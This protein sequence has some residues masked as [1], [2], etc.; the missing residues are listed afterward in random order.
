MGKILMIQKEGLII[1]PSLGRILFSSVSYCNSILSVCI[2]EGTDDDSKSPSGL[3]LTSNV[4][5]QNYRTTITP[6]SC[7]KLAAEVPRYHRK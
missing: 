4:Y 1:D 6:D 5:L 2:L 3:N 7:V